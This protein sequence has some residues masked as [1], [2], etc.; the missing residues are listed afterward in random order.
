MSQE[1]SFAR[2]NPNFYTKAVCVLPVIF[3]RMKKSQSKEICQL[4]PSVLEIFKN[5]IFEIPT[6]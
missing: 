3:I 1:F 2:K 4:T 5:S 6:N